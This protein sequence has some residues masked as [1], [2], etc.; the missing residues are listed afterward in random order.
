MGMLGA[1]KKFANSVNAIFKTKQLDEDTIEE[2]EALLYTSDFGA[3]IVDLIISEIK[4]RYAKT[5]SIEAI[6]PEQIA[7]EVILEKLS[8]SEAE[9]KAPFDHKPKVIVLIGVNGAGKTTTA[10]KLAHKVNTSGASVL[11]SACDTFRAAANEQIQTW[12]KTLNIA[13]ITSHHGADSAAVAY[14]SLEAAK[15]RKHDLLII[16]T[17]GRLHTKK[18]LMQELEKLNRVLRKQ[19][20]NLKIEH[21]LVIDGSVGSNSIDQAKAFNASIPLDGLIVTKLDGTSRGGSLIGI[22]E[23]LKI[24]I[25][26]IGTGE[27]PE[28]LHPFSIH[29]YIEALFRNES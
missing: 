18:N 10:A 6:K 20:P 8:G 29:Q 21:W 27:K 7:S 16:D 25:Y 24:P 5:K 26:F 12:A 3:E 1:F 4:E 2:L 13:I 11:L 15:K 23:S 28:D 9:F 19:D 14:D 22:Y 17:A